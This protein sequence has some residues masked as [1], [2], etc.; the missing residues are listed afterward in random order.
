MTVLRKW[1]E[2]MRRAAL[3]RTDGD[4]AA[5]MTS[6]MSG[7]LARSPR[8][9]DLL[10]DRHDGIRIGEAVEVGCLEVPRLLNLDE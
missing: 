5:M 9:C 8:L 2:G 4:E 3:V 6:E 1:G 10:S 7:S